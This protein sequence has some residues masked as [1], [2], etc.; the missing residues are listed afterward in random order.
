MWFCASVLLRSEV[1]TDRIGKDNVEFEERLFLLQADEIS[2]AHEK[3]LEI[4][5]N[6][7]HSYEN[8]GGQS[9]NWTFRRLIRV[10]EVSDDELKAG[11]E[12]FFRRLGRREGE[13]LDR[14]TSS[15]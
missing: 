13:D 15:V 7:D 6:L 9:V 12:V 10:C 4:G 2:E 8:V 11:S 1:K 14:R 5:R 3:A